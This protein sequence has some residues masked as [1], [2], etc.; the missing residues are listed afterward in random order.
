MQG[1]VDKNSPARLEG[2][3]VARMR[4]RLRVDF[5]QRA[6]GCTVPVTAASEMRRRWW[7]KWE[8]VAERDTPYLVHQP[9]RRVQPRRGH[10][11]PRGGGAQEGA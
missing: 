8:W 11:A 6:S 3:G 10:Q 1:T 5:A 2:L 7:V 9:L 4:T